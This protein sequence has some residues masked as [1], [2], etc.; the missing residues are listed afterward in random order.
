V[1][2]FKLFR[3]VVLLSIFFVILLSTWMNER[4][5]ASWERPIWVTV[6]PIVADKS[7]A[8]RVH[9]ESIEESTFADINRF[10][11]REMGLYG[12]SLTPTFNFQLAPV[13]DELPPA[14]PERYDSIAIAFWSLK[15]R[16]WVW[17]MQRN[18]GLAVADIQLFVL[19]HAQGVDS[20]MKMSVGM[21]KGMYGLVKAYTGRGM[22]DQNNVIIAHELLH[23]FGATDKYTPGTAQPEFPDGLADPERQPLYPQVAAEIMGGSIPLSPYDFVIPASLDQ[24]RMGHKTAEEIGLFAQLQKE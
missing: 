1:S 18:D 8:T 14:I 17:R 13:S 6:Y 10:F 19:Y 15:M 9:A 4:R 5:L 16:W 24:C 23:I 12:V 3:V 2:L 11:E 7:P 20:E 21:R 22:T